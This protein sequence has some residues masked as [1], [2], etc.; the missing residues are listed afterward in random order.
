M[1]PLPPTPAE[2]TLRR[3]LLIAALDGWSVIAVAGLGVLLTLLLGD[4]SGLLVGALVLTG[5]VLEL[6]GRG[7]LLRRDATGM[8]LMARA[9]LLM[10]SV[11]LV[12]CVSRLGSFD[13]E[14]VL[15]SLTPE[16]E[17]ML[18]ESGVERADL[19]PLVQIAFYSTYATAAL[20]SLL[21]QGGLALYYRN[22]AGLVATALADAQTPLA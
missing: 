15:S 14:T 3:V 19:L 12:Y 13:S 7:R 4:L 8:R 9:Q 17:A 18:K 6:R 11:I 20:A 10:L 1:A 22:R 21:F 16:M 5:G 2:K